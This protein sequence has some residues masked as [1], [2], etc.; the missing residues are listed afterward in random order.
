MAELEYTVCPVCYKERVARGETDLTFGTGLC[1][2]C[3]SRFVGDCIEAWQRRQAWDNEVIGGYRRAELAYHDEHWYGGPSK[4]E[5]C[6]DRE[7][8]G[9][10][11]DYIVLPGGKEV[12]L[13]HACYDAWNAAADVDVDDGY[14]WLMSPA[15]AAGFQWHGVEGRDARYKRERLERKS[16]E[17]RQ[18][19][20]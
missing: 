17:E 11:R 14:Y 16:V 3:F 5:R 15:A 1:L 18:G 2:A 9:G 7:S 12:T 20:V 6:G 4:C 10:Y 13:C 8:C 19:G